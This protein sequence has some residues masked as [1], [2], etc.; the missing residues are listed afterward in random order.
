MKKLSLLAFVAMALLALSCDPD[1]LP[2]KIYDTPYVEF[3]ED[4]F[5]ISATGGEFIVPVSSTGVDNV[6]I[7]LDKEDS[8]EVDP[9]S[10]DLTPKDGWITLVE[11]INEYDVPTRAL[12][13]WDS[14]ISILV[15]PNT[16]GRERKALITVTS[17]MAKDAIEVI[18]RAE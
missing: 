10:G 17:F 11:V 14:G 5:V 2:F 7:G 15:E 16:T 4:S 1:H 18:Q 12:A 6:T 3:Y 8:F 9:D 13:K